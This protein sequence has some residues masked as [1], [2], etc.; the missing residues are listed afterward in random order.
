MNSNSSDASY[1]PMY[2]DMQWM[3]GMEKPKND[4]EPIWTL[5]TTQPA[6]VI[7]RN[8]NKTNLIVNAPPTIV[9]KQNREIYNL[10]V[11]KF[12]YKK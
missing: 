4:P 2:D 1:N 9:P 8:V 6:A 12:P 11:S 7:P 10:K 3:V 5:D